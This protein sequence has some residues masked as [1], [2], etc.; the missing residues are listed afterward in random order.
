MKGETMSPS[1]ASADESR[2]YMSDESIWS[3]SASSLTGEIE[4]GER[5]ETM[6]E[7]P[8][9]SK[10][11]VPA[12]LGSLN[13]APDDAED[14]KSPQV[15]DCAPESQEF[16]KA[17]LSL[18]FTDSETS[19]N[20]PI[21]GDMLS[22]VTEIS[23]EGSL[24]SVEEGANVAKP[25]QLSKNSQSL[26]HLHPNKNFDAEGIS[27]S[28]SSND[29]DTDVDDGTV[30]DLSSCLDESKLENTQS[31]F[32]SDGLIIPGDEPFCIQYPDST[33][34][35]PASTSNMSLV[36][37]TGNAAAS[38]DFNGR[39]DDKSDVGAEENTFDV[40]EIK[41]PIVTACPNDPK[42]EATLSPSNSENSTNALAVSDDDSTVLQSP[43]ST[44]ETVKTKP[45]PP[46]KLPKLNPS[47]HDAN[48]RCGENSGGCIAA[49]PSD[50]CVDAAFSLAERQWEEAAAILRA[51]PSLMSG[52]ILRLALH[53]CPP[54]HV[55]DFMLKLSP[56]AAAVPQSGPSALQVAVR[57]GASLEVVE[58][59][60]RACPYA[61][62]TG[63]GSYDPLT[64]AKIWRSEEKDLIEMLSRPISR[65]VDR[66]GRDQST[67][68]KHSIQ[69]TG[70][71]NGA[72]LLS[73]EQRELSNLKLITAAV[74]KSQRKHIADCKRDREEAAAER[75]AL[76]LREKRAREVLFE[77]FDD[78][79][80]KLMKAQ[81]VA[82][83]MKEKA[84]ESKISR[85][86]RSLEGLLRQ[87][88]EEQERFAER[89][90][91]REEESRT[92]AE[93]EF[94]GMRDDIICAANRVER[95]CESYGTRLADLAARVDTESARHAAFREELEIKLDRVASMQHFIIHASPLSAEEESPKSEGDELQPLFN[96]CK[97]SKGSDS[98]DATF[99]DDWNVRSC[100]S[101][102]DEPR[103]YSTWTKVKNKVT[104]RKN[105]R[106]K[107]R[108]FHIL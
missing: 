5:A 18:T 74:V 37:K 95:S 48:R 85:L 26:A 70:S 25:K 23:T 14:A 54:R 105:Q 52:H 42:V 35:D 87:S 72:T 36:E 9:Y 8:Y 92:L 38:V 10:V 15:Y 16:P 103:K 94:S 44:D 13:C 27:S 65:W 55:V 69:K 68:R 1:T 83:D 66:K 104:R 57:H 64:Y 49:V 2:S 98:N 81:L 11:R 71:S 53:N 24:E 6:A 21:A 7:V 88:L 3:A 20:E 19:A 101:S 56:S 96:K 100:S 76:E 40:G 34:S 59:V 84:F 33:K 67:S 30:S 80:R 43:E 41:I 17:D 46:K 12:A 97:E 77:S 22:V 82:L 91:A 86:G 89:R 58:R 47:P 63:N 62:F 75:R 99:S 4:S 93:S 31:E 51:A 60:I 29:S 39:T 61:L 45:R 108:F 32:S 79:E 50:E 107:K 78:R 106:E 90:E 102:E 73:E 28:Y